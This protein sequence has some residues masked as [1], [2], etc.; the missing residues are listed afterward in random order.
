MLPIETLLFYL[1]YC[2]NDATI[3][4]ERVT[5]QSRTNTN[6]HLQRTRIY[7]SYALI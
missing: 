3:V 6:D 2:D 7:G 4:Y 1:R 5:I